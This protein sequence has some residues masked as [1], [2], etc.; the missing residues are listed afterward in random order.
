MLHSKKIVRAPDGDEA[1]DEGSYIRQFAVLHSV[2]LIALNAAVEF[3][4]TPSL[5]V[6]Y[7]SQ[8]M[9]FTTFFGTGALPPNPNGPLCGRNRNL[10]RGSKSV[11]KK[12]E[13]SPTRQNL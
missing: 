2:R 5:F 7:L 13:R 4:M 12:F 10:G 3:Y 11:G 9:I 1:F 6:I 8:R